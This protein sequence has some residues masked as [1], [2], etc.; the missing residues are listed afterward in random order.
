MV[1]LPQ[2]SV[3]PAASQSANKNINVEVK[4]DPDM[5]LERAMK[6][7]QSHQPRSIESL[8]LSA[9][10]NPCYCNGQPIPV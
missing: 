2:V 10:A 5:L 3:E 6:S 9:A 7:Y 1:E 4:I 8:S